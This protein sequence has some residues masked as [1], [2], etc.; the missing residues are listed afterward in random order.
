MLAA[1]VYTAHLRDLLVL[2]NFLTALLGVQFVL[3]FHQTAQESL[4]T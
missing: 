4:T 1:V 2:G 3:Q